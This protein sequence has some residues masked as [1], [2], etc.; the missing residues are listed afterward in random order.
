MIIQAK[1]HK[2]PTQQFM[3]KQVACSQNHGEI[4]CTRRGRFVGCWPCERDL[5]GEGKIL[6]FEL[7]HEDPMVSE[8]DL[9]LMFA[10]G[11]AV[12][13]VVDAHIRYSVDQ[14]PSSYV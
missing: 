5:G 2:R 12:P 8:Q 14:V 10:R 6:L 13:S 7:R 4:V 3:Y 11:F 9:N 1:S